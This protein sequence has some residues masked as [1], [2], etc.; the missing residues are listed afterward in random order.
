MKKYLNFYSVTGIL[1]FSYILIRSVTVGVTYDEAWTLMDFVPLNILQVLNCTPCDANNHII[2]TLLIKLV[3][4]FTPDSLFW[5]RVPNILA[6][7]VYIGMGHRIASRFLP[8][9]LG[10]ALFLLLLVNPF[11]LEF[12]SLARG[13]GLS[14]ALMLTSI[15]QLLLFRQK[16][17]VIHAFFALGW[18]SLGVLSN[19]SLLNYWCGA[20]LV[21]ILLAFHLKSER[22][23]LLKIAGVALLWGFILLAIM[24]EP[25]RK[26]IQFGGLYYG[27]SFGFY[28]DTIGTLVSYSMYDPYPSEIATFIEGMLTA[29]FILV[30]MMG[31]L[32]L[33]SLKEFMGSKA[34]MITVL[35]GTPILANITQHL[36]FDTLYLVSRT[37]LFYYPL[38]I[39]VFI[40][41]IAEVRNRF[42]ALSLKAVAA[43]LAVLFSVNFLQHA[44]F[45]KTVTWEFDAHNREILEALQHKAEKENKRYVIGAVP[46]YVR[47]LLYQIDDFPNVSYVPELNINDSV[48]PDYFLYYD[49][50]LQRIGY[51][52]DQQQVHQFEKDTLLQFPGEAVYMFT[53]FSKTKED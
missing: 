43:T 50:D 24:Y 38:F 6:G 51:F 34:V 9:Y 26:L 31:L 44:N 4:L 52:A 30:I 23:V 25:V 3:Y 41:W 45:H 1:F 49:K 53:N 28:Q 10:Y 11:L 18:A 14:L 29:V 48:P 35:T 40:F 8:G 7:L 42:A 13:Y 36:L 37:A 21:M 2:N 39:L 19:F 46:L 12:F 15:Y 16:G 5:A 47:G 33:R 32:S 20:L 17:K 22:R 27:G